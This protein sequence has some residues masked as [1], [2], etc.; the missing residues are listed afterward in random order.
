MSPW[1]WLI[2]ILHVIGDFNCLSLLPT[3]YNYD[4]KKKDFILL[5][6]DVHIFYYIIIMRFFMHFFS[7]LFSTQQYKST[8][9]NLSQDIYAN[10]T[11]NSCSGIDIFFGFSSALYAAA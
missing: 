1:E 3:P 5:K 10:F 2:F 11:Y 6:S 8:A 4:W 7:R 9:N